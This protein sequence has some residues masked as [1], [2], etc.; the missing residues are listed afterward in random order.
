MSAKV[1]VMKEPNFA[2]LFNVFLVCI[3]NCINLTQFLN[4]FNK[5]G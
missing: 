1:E 2:R 4:D 5:L 3:S